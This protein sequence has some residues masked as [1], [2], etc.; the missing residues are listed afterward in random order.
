MIEM[1]THCWKC[2][3]PEPL[4]HIIDEIVLKMCKGCA[5]ELK[6]YGDFLN[7][8]G[9]EVRGMKGVVKGVEG[10][11]NGVDKGVVPEKVKP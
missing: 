1:K 7:A 9:L 4:E 11:E 5:Y 2:F 6:R 3:K 8:H 10:G